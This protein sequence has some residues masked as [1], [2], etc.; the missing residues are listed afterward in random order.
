MKLASKNHISSTRNGQMLG[1]ASESIQE[2]LKRVCRRPEAP[3]QRY[4]KLRGDVQE[5]KSQI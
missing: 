5:A 3:F 2:A 1:Q 4:A